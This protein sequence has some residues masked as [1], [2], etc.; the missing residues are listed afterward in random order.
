MKAP[1]GTVDLFAWVSE[2]P[3]PPLKLTHTRTAN[4]YLDSRNRW[5][6]VS[7]SGCYKQE[8][9]VFCSAW[10]SFIVHHHVALYRRVNMCGSI[11]SAN[12][13]SRSGFLFIAIHPPTPVEF[14]DLSG[15]IDYF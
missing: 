1:H 11:P 12:V 14:S 7:I 15:K 5:S 13:G 3:P 9:V 8:T 6:V 2:P 10:P 4:S